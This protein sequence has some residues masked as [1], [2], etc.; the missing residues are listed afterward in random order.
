[1]NT[2]VTLSPFG[3]FTNTA[4]MTVAAGDSFTVNSLGQEAARPYGLFS[5]Q[6]IVYDYGTMILNTNVHQAD[7][8]QIDVLNG[9][10]LVLDGMTAAGG[11]IGI[12][13][14]TLEFSHAPTFHGGPWSAM[15]FMANVGF[16]GTNDIV[17]FDNVH[18]AMTEVFRAAQQD[19]LVFSGATQVADLHLAQIAGGYAASNFSVSDNNLI[20]HATPWTP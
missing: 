8:A 17:K 16:D 11:C 3:T 9:G 18:T 2:T 20:F 5:N 12:T 7:N 14:A 4:A 15:C 6:G 1:M 19:V 13:N 10:R